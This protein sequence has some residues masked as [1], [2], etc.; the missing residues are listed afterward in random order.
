M[1]IHYRPLLLAFAIVYAVLAVSSL[2]IAMSL[3]QSAMP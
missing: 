2:L 3:A 1:K